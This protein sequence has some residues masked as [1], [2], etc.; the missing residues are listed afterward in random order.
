LDNLK[1]FNCFCNNGLCDI[2]VSG[3]QKDFQG[4]PLHINRSESAQ[5]VD[6]FAFVGDMRIDAL[7]GR[8]YNA[9]MPNSLPRIL[10][11]E[12]PFHRLFKD[13]YSLERYP[14]SLGYL[15]GAIL[16]AGGWDVKTYNADFTPNGELIRVSHLS[17]EGYHHFRCNIK[18]PVAPVWEQ[19]RRV[20]A[21]VG[22]D[23]VAISTK[24]QTHASARLVAR[25]VK[26]QNPDT[27]VLVGGPHPTILPEKVL[28]CSDFDAAMI[29]EGEETIVELLAAIRDGNKWDDVAG[30]AF[31]CEEQI[32][33]TAPRALMENLDTLPFPHTNASQT[34]IDYKQYPPGAFRFVFA[35]RGCPYNC[36]FCGSRRIWTRRVRYRSV[37]NVVAELQS[38]QA[39][40][41]KFVHFDDDTF[42][43]SPSYIRRLCE[44]ITEHCPNLR[45]S[46]ELHVKLVR[47]DLLAVMRK[48]GCYMIQVGVESGS[49]EILR[50]MR[51]GFTIA[52]AMD[53]CRRITAHGIWLQTFFMV[54][55]PQETEQ[56]L[57]ETLRAMKRIASNRVMYSIFTPYPGTEAYEFCRQ[58]NLVDEAREASLYYHQNPENCFCLHISPERF[59]RLVRDV[60]RTV[61]RRNAWRRIREIASVNTWNR[62][63][64]LGLAGALRK[65]WRVLRGR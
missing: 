22:P 21:D 19:V 38:L 9:P 47:D 15:A 12:P 33:R 34:L 17:G 43:V 63:R 64:E 54:G 37:E 28:E 45:W 48:A 49:D 5:S 1:N 59:R 58:H 27:V 10:L 32:I 3:G 46:C 41:L 6:G 62:I 18:E 23:V 60:E 25:L 50:A 36:V 24:T 56:T 65:G 16:A 29:G 61:D 7:R 52:E 44:A 4:N 20:L 14:L 40:G 31:R 26:Q 55:F 57:A 35:L 11:I 53:A 30:V 8:N 39:M 13:S 2:F 51:K 42:G